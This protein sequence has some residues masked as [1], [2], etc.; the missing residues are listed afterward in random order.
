MRWNAKPRAAWCCL[1]VVVINLP[2]MVEDPQHAANIRAHKYSKAVNDLVAKKYPRVC[3]VDFQSA[4]RQYMA[5]HSA[6]WQQASQEMQQQQQQP[7][8]QMPNSGTATGPGT[9]PDAARKVYSLNV[10]NLVGHMAWSKAYQGMLMQRTWDDIS[11]MQGL[12]LLTDQIHI[13]D[14]AAKILADLVQPLLLPL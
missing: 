3:L 11:R 9:T 10:Y 6:A 1:Q 13:N 12:Y 7:P 5:E 2:I 14:T 4:C 8:P